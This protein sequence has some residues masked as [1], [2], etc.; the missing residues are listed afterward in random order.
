MANTLT[1]TVSSNQVT[2]AEVFQ[3]RLTYDDKIDSD[4][5][6]FSVLQNQFF[7]GQP[8]FGSS[9]NYVNGKRSSRSEWTIALKAKQLGTISIPSFSIDGA[10]SQP[11]VIKVSQ[12]KDLPKPSELVTIQAQLDKKSL[13][14]N[15]ATQLKT[16]L[17]IKSDPRRLQ[18]VKISP[19]AGESF[20]VE[21]EGEPNQYQTIINGVEATVV[22][23]TFKVIATQN[24]S[25]ILNSLGFEATFVFGNNR[26]GTT[27]LLPVKIAPEQ[28]AIDVK[29]KPA[30]SDL[31]WLPTSKLTLSQQWLDDQG[32]P[33]SLIKQPLELKL[34][35]SITRQ[36]TLT[37]QGI[38]AENFPD[39]SLIYPDAVRHYSEKPQFKT[40]DNG[41]TQMTIRQ[42]L[43]AQH[44]GKAVLPPISIPWFDTQ[45]DVAK[46]TQVDGVEL[47]IEAAAI[48]ANPEI[49]A[50]INTTQQLVTQSGFWPYLTILFA[51]LWL[52]TLLWHVNSRNKNTAINTTT[53][54]HANEFK[55]VISTVESN[56]TVQ[57]QYAVKHW[58]TTQKGKNDQIE[59]QILAELSMMA[60]KQ[61]SAHPD[62]WNNRKLVD[63]IKK[64]YKQRA[65]NQNSNNLTKL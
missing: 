38:E 14:P 28:L 26:S 16:R 1:A 7:L 21:Q 41:Q 6:D 22:D 40:L 55:Q 65:N 25:H 35:D 43:I 5:I 20:T 19:P 45:N 59:Q 9:L 62:K 37:I 51:L 64:L 33:V 15:E 36:L 61:Y 48:T 8:S 2:K 49:S 23:Q 11:I 60:T 54:N 31:V 29:A 50:P 27:K 53:E 46:Q 4:R 24:G 3:L 56:D 30:D 44:A 52:I 12:D 13:Y 32:N 58:L 57:I 10:S 39:I 18:D 63:L 47:N 42:V 34:G 17:I